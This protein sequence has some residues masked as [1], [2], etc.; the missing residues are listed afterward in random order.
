LGSTEGIRKFLGVLAA[1]R[2]ALVSGSASVLALVDRPQVREL[3]SAAVVHG[4]D[5]IGLERIARDA[6]LAADL[7]SAS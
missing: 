2:L 6:G 7:A 3:L 4:N 5:V 1:F